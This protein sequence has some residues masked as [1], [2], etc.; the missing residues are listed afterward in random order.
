M[1]LTSL[2]K[3][4]P[5][6]GGLYIF[7]REAYGSLAGSLVAYL[8]WV[9]NLVSI[10]GIAVASISYLGYFNPALD[11]HSLHYNHFITLLV[12]LGT[13]WLFTT[14]N[15]IG[16]HTAGIIQLVL[17]IVKIVPLLVIALLG[18]QYVSLDNFNTASSL[19]PFNVSSLSLIGS[20]AA[21][22]FW[23]YIGIESATIPAE[24]Y[25]WLA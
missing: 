15:I 5:K 14:I 22:T 25:Q 13:V 24:E 23:A 9:S 21:L 12:E 17:T 3:R 4:F 18:L 11:S 8:Y 6:T 19:E 10:A 20:A 1:T 2:N 16:I 7:C